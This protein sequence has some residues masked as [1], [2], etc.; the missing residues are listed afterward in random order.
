M[1]DERLRGAQR[2]WEASGNSADEA[3]VLAKRL[4]A[5]HLSEKDVRLAAALGSEAAR[6][7]VGLPEAYFPQVSDNH[8]LI[9]WV[10]RVTVVTDLEEGLRLGLSSVREGL[11]LLD[12]SVLATSVRQYF[13]QMERYWQRD[14]EVQKRELPLLNI[15]IN[16]LS[17]LNDSHGYSQDSFVSLILLALMDWMLAVYGYRQAGESAHTSLSLR[18]NTVHSCVCRAFRDPALGERQ[19]TE[20][21]AAE[22]LWHRCRGDLLGRLLKHGEDPKVDQGEETQEIDISQFREQIGERLV[23]DSDS[24]DPLQPDSSER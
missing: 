18:L 2:R 6:L 24:E 4:R 1:A 15:W 8:T 11:E 12:D 7:V 19:L 14:E 22:R 10:N 17:V 9:V 3:A 21:Q 23:T 5:G 20:E 16:D 13:E